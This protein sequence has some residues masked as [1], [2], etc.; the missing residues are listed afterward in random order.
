MIHRFTPAA[1]DGNLQVLNLKGAMSD[2]SGYL[3]SEND[4]F[5]GAAG[6]RVSIRG[7][8]TTEYHRFPGSCPLNRLAWL[9]GGIGCGHTPHSL[10]S[11]LPPDKAAELVAAVREA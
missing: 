5:R 2:F 10:S 1:L 8:L 11:G 6:F 9:E 3:P 7:L 4:L